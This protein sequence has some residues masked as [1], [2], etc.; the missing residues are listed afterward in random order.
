MTTLPLQNTNAPLCA[1]ELEVFLDMPIPERAHILRPVIATQSINMC[2][3]PRGVGKTFAAGSIAL[4]VASGGSVYGWQAPCPQKVMYIDG[5]M[6]AVAMKE[7]FSSLIKGMSIPPVALKNIVLITPD[8]QSRPMPDLASQ[9]GQLLIEPLLE[10]V[11]LII[12]DNIA[13]LCRSGK[14]NE[15]NSWQQMQ[16]WLL[17]LRRRGMSVLLIHHSGKNG[18]QRGT[19]ARED[20]MDTVISLRRPQQYKMSEGARF[21]V[22]LTKARNLSGEEAE[23]FEAHLQDD[24][25]SLAWAVSKIEDV[26]AKELQALLDAG[27]TIRE[28]AEEMGISKSAAGRI[29]KQLEAS[30]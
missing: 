26:R 8:L 6:P 24:G 21:E 9:A 14:E 12:I 27:C 13:T 5:E 30:R 2:H 28:A 7:R 17:D 10:G 22:H 29:K 18:D 20:I 23:P 15:A 25:E 3:A 11:S 1:V 4:A 19:S 16:A